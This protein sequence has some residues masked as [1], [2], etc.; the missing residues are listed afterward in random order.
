MNVFGSYR[1]LLH[2]SKQAMLASIE[3]YNKPKFD[4]R[5]EV[6]S[7]LLINAWELLFLGILSKNR[8]RIFQ[9]KKP[10][11]KYQTLQFSDLIK[12]VRPY[13]PMKMDHKAVFEN[14]NL[15]KDHR[16]N[17]VHYYNEKDIAHCIYVLAQAAIKNYRDLVQAIFDQDV[18]NEINLVLLPLSFNKQPDFVEFFKGVKKEKRSPLANELFR[19]WKELEASNVDTSQLI[20]Q[21]TIKLESV[22]KIG[23]A[24]FTVAVDNSGDADGI[25]ITR[26]T[27]PDDTH[28]FFRKD[29]IGYKKTPPHKKLNKDI[30]T[31]QFQAIL[32]KY[33]LSKN[34]D[35][36]WKSTKGGPP[37]YSQKML[38][39]INSLS[40]EDIDKAVKDFKTKK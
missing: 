8:Q 31:H 30:T 23:S 18:V 9:D 1:K 16:D 11:A 27:N 25:V 5:E 29:I 40:E 28:P 26:N 19:A 7:I 4:Y 20:T 37:R 39:K 32:R 10:K 38:E 36:C 17:S 12:K 24:D 13:L 14:L 21:C 33:D 6:F 2:N 3:I 22:K 15:L 35:Y 34:K